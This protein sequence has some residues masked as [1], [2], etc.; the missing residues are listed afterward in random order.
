MLALY[1]GAGFE[2]DATKSRRGPKFR[3]GCLTALHYMMLDLWRMHVC[4]VEHIADFCH[5]CFLVVLIPD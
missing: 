5:R 2:A 4:L 3:N 1:F